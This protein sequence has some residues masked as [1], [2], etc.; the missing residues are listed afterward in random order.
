MLK[1]GRPFP[2]KPFSIELMSLEIGLLLYSKQQHTF[3]RRFYTQRRVNSA[4]Y[5]NGANEEVF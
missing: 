1:V 2:R 4:T 3:R 5:T